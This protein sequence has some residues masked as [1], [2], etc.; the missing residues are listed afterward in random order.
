MN[1]MLPITARLRSK[2][3]G[4]VPIS[5]VA[6]ET[7]QL[8]PAIEREHPAAI[9][10]PSEFERVLA[11]MHE[12]ALEHELGRLRQGTRRH[13]PTIA[14]RLDNA[15]LAQG[16]L[17]FD[18]GH[19]VIRGGCDALL[20]RPQDRLTE[21]QLC[22]NY[23]IERYFGHWLIDGRALELLADQMSLRG[24]VLNRKPWLHEPGYRKMSDTEA[25]RTDNALV[26]RLWVIDDHSVNENRIARIGELR[27]RIRAAARP[28]DKK[29]IV[30]ARGTL[31]SP[32]DLIN[33]DEVYQALQ[34]EGFEIINPEHETVGSIVNAL[35]SA[36]IVIAVEG[37]V[38]SHCTY[39]MPVG[40]TLLTIQPPTRFNAVSKDRAD[41]VGMNW[42]FVVADPREDDFYLP[43]DRLDRTL[44]EVSRVSGQRAKV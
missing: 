26:G 30:L 12:T 15:I 5:D 34:K 19:S 32:R 11:V 3:L 16:S 36:E 24:L 4:N 10:L 6:S 8:A 25:V 2:W 39:A 44:E 17:Y 42:A 35:S 33:S 40:S 37:S 20:P 43:L 41:A 18:G 31:G 13:G 23:F 38:Q 29:R 14:Y 22:T 21:M 7:I 1:R 28:T 27:S 9:A